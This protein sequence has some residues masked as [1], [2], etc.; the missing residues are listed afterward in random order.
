MVNQYYTPDISDIRIA[1]E[2]EQY[3]PRFYT[4]NEGEVENRS[5]WYKKTISEPLMYGDTLSSKIN[6]KTIRVPYLTKEQI[7]VEGWFNGVGE[8][9]FYKNLSNVVKVNNEYFIDGKLI[10]YEDY[11]LHYNYNTHILIIGN[12]ERNYLFQGYCFSI[13]EFRYITNKLLNI[14]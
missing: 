9:W 7:E 3:H 6:N 5:V 10:S 12:E 4:N 2:Y 11:E 13:N 1:Y 14:N 8:N